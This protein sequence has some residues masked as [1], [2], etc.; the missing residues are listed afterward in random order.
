MV[1]RTNGRRC[2]NRSRGLLHCNRPPS[3]PHWRTT[4]N[5]CPESPQFLDR[6]DSRSS[7]RRWTNSRLLVYSRA[8]YKRSLLSSGFG[9]QAR[10]TLEVALPRKWGMQTCVLASNIALSQMFL[11]EH[12][13]VRASYRHSCS[14]R[15]LVLRRMKQ[16]CCHPRPH[17]QVF[18]VQ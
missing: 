10:R 3:W 5:K 13:R 18:F 16:A 14:A 12:K 8:T 2:A 9:R 15:D 11:C 1:C 17:V 7:Y 6:S 4:C